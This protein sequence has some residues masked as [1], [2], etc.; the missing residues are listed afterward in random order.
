M[1]YYDND[2]ATFYGNSIYGSYQIGNFVADVRNAGTKT[3]DSSPVN[4]WPNNRV[5]YAVILSDNGS[6]KFNAALNGAL[7]VEDTV[8]TPAGTMTAPT[9][10]LGGAKV[11]S[12]TYATATYKLFCQWD[13]ALSREEIANWSMDPYQILEAA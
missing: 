6:N 1:Q 3:G 12:A 9:I 5:P 10:I 13:R 4:Y 11:P 7:G 2:D 8:Y